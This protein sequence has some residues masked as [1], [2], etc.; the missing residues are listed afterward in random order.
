MAFGT[1]FAQTDSVAHRH[2]G[3]MRMMSPKMIDRHLHMMK[4]KLNLTDAQ[5]DQL[6]S[7]MQ[8]HM[9]KMKA[10]MD[11]IKNALKGSDARKDARKQ[12]VEDRKA[13]MNMDDVKSVLTP[14]QFKKFKAMRLMQIERSEKRLQ[15]QKKNLESK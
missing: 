12:M 3:M 9:D 11:A 7:I 5:V 10:D 14:E 8:Q 13:M 1:S 6:K 2:P 15:A 4:T